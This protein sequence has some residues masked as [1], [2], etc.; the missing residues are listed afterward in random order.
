MG[1][2]QPEV[3]FA[4]HSGQVLGRNRY[5]GI[6]ERAATAAETVSP[7]AAQAI[8]A[9][10]TFCSSCNSWTC[11][12]TNAVAFLI[13]VDLPVGCEVNGRAPSAAAAEVDL[14]AVPERAVSGRAAQAP[15]MPWPGR[16]THPR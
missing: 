12:G 2:G 16:S 5:Q 6:T 10:S 7:R 1:D 3:P 8:G 15:P 14:A 9:C 11:A 4:H 13:F